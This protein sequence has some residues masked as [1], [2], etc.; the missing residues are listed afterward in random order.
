MQANDSVTLSRLFVN[1]IGTKNGLI[2]LHNG[3]S[4]VDLSFVWYYVL[5][6]RWLVTGS[7]ASF[8]QPL[9]IGLAI[10]RTEVGSFEVSLHRHS[11]CFI[12]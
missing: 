2:K 4:E 10:I 7:R 6:A 9:K 1:S 5:R 3:E 11:I 12:H 8:S